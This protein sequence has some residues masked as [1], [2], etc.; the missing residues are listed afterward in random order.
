M[1]CTQ[2]TDESGR[3]PKS[4]V[5]RLSMLVLDLLT[6]LLPVELMTA[7]KSIKMEEE[8]RTA[9]Y[10]SLLAGQLGSSKEEAKQQNYWSS[11]FMFAL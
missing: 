8:F 10:S 11:E 3:R 2:K 7:T 5:V 4:M 9:G 1:R 6:T